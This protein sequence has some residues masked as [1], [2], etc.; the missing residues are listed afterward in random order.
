MCRC[1]CLQYGQLDSTKNESTSPLTCMSLAMPHIPGDGR[2]DTQWI[3]PKCMSIR[4][5]FIMD[6]VNEHATQCNVH[7]MCSTHQ[8][9][10]QLYQPAWGDHHLIPHGRNVSIPQMLWRVPG[11]G[12]S[13]RQ[14]GCARTVA[15]YLQEEWAVEREDNWLLDAGSRYTV[16]ILLYNC[17]D[18]EPDLKCRTHTLWIHCGKTLPLQ[19]VWTNYTAITTLL[20]RDM[21]LS[22]RC[23]CLGWIQP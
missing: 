18:P 9:P 2:L 12:P 22:V 7:G 6:I 10:A 5:L 23:N 14:W 3:G 11:L 13:Q 15:V 8:T 4:G 21:Y 16:S 1:G 17:T 20:I 19:P